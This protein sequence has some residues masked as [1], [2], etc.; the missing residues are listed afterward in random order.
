[1]S[2]EQDAPRVDEQASA[3]DGNASE[4]W[5]D[6]VAQLEAFTSAVGRW[7]KA[8]AKDPDNKRRVEELK[9]GLDKVAASIGGAPKPPTIW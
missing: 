5:H 8:A 1:M 7:A 2:D 4:A 9:A 6:V 3:A